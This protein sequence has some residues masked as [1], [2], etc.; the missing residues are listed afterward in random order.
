MSIEIV[1]AYDAP[2][3]IGSLFSEYTE[4]L[5]QASPAFSQYLKLQNYE[6]E[7]RHLETKYGLPDGRLYLASSGSTPAGCIALRRID[8]ERCEM[9]RLYVKPVFR[10]KRIGNIL[11]SKIISDAREIG[12]RQMLL[13]TFP[14][15][16]AAIRLYQQVGFYEIPS[17]NDN[18]MDTLVYMCLDL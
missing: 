17:Y 14:F 8:A 3:E 7:L 11:I 15:L 1:P 18:P 12:Y 2:Q 16:Q 6:D 13:D 10:G 5:I 4:M 9:K